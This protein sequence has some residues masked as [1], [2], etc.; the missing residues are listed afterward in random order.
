MTS[1]H[2]RVEGVTK[3]YPGGLRAVDGIDLHVGAGEFFCLLGPSGCGKTTLLGIIAGLVTPDAG[4]VHLA[5]REITQQPMNRREIGMVFQSYALFPHLNVRDN[6]AFGLKVRRTSRVEIDNRTAELLAVVGLTSKSAQLPSE[7]SGGEQQRV[8][9]ARALAI[10]PRVL[11]LD[12]PFSNLDAKLRVELRSDLRRIQR[13]LGITT[14]MVTHDQDEAFALADTIGL[15]ERGKL[16]Q[17]GGAEDLYTRPATRFVARFIGDSN[18]LSGSVERVGSEIVLR[19]EG[20]LVPAPLA[21]MEGARVTITVRPERVRLGTSPLENGIR[22][23]VRDVTYRG[24]GW[25]YELDTEVG[26]L[27]AL[28]ATSS[29]RRA[30]VGTEVFASWSPNDAVVIE[31]DAVVD[32]V[33]ASEGPS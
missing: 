27:L 32:G 33:K 1:P 28:D 3:T 15:V 9:L 5:G 10:R 11:L 6:V 18:L 20:A 14:V 30:D 23:V 24:L 12:E 31:D 13:E 8:A 29:T 25:M 16:V 21:S 19:V 4:S 22:A 7:L 17:V 26:P 2:L